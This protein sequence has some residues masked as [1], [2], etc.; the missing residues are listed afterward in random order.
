MIPLLLEALRALIR[1]LFVE[2]PHERRC[3]RIESAQ[4]RIEMLQRHRLAG[5]EDEVVRAIAADAL[6][7]RARRALRRARGRATA[8]QVSATGRIH[9]GHLGRA[10][11]QLPPTT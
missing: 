8:D 3:T 6:G 2:V 1:D 4:S 7:R 9:A 5:D 11:Q 10:G